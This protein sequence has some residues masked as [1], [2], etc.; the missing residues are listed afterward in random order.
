MFQADYLDYIKR[1]SNKAFDII[2]LD[3]PYA[4][5]MYAPALS[6]MLDAL[7]IKPTT[8]I[9]CESGENEIFDGNINLKGRFNIEKQ[10]KYS[11]TVITLLKLKE[12]S[13]NE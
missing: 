8:I 3:P 9:V 10:S 13:E 4:K 12:N 11:N 1:N 2:I 5:K 7:F 6:A